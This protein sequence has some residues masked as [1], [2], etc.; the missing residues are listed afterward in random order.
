MM[1]MTAKPKQP[2]TPT[3]VQSKATRRRFTAAY[4]LEIVRR[5]D[6]CK[7]DGGTEAM[8]RREGLYSSHLCEWRKLRASGALNETSSNRRGPKPKVED[9]RDREIAAMKK[10]IARLEAR[11]RR[12]E[13]LVEL[14]KKV[15][16]LL[17]SMRLDESD[18]KR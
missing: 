8:L 18:K 1:L 13:A 17:E 5:A 11:A 4:K 6:D 14:Q 16:E 12:A 15:G 2:P 9:P 3:E 7:E 10:E